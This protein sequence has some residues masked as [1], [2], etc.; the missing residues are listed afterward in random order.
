[1]VVSVVQSLPDSEESSR[2]QHHCSSGL[3]Y[4]P[5]WPCAQCVSVFPLPNRL[6]RLSFAR[7]VALLA[8]VVHSGTTWWLTD[9]CRPSS[10]LHPT[11]SIVLSTFTNW[12]NLS[13]AGQL[14]LL[15]C[16]SCCGLPD[17]LQAGRSVVCVS[18][19]ARLTVLGSIWLHCWW[20]GG[21]EGS[22]QSSQSCFIS[23]R[24]I[25]LTCRLCWCIFCSL[26]TAHFNL[27][28]VVV[29]HVIYDR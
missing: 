18:Y 23:A 14:L 29:V 8:A 3:I 17:D 13:S 20:T 6:V 15:L 25:L 1:M 21:N 12:Y 9:S 24:S 16:C 7:L 22:L 10:V 27:A 26:F 2:E 28:A 5:V 4:G 19:W 11:C